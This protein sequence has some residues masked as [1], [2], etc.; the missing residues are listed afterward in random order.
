[1]QATDHHVGRAGRA[2]DAAAAAYPLEGAAVAG[3][4]YEQQRI[5]LANGAG[6][7]FSVS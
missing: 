2:G 1:M 5:T 6:A 4:T 7:S 3:E